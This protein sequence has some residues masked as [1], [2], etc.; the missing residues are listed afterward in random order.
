MGKVDPK[1]THSVES[2]SQ[3]FNEGWHIYMDTRLWN[4]ITI[5]KDHEV[6][7]FPEKN[8]LYTNMPEDNYAQGEWGWVDEAGRKLLYDQYQKVKVLED[9]LSE[10]YGNKNGPR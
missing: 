7:R 6:V 3:L 2:L 4:G 1:A 8:G 9:L 10:N 5:H